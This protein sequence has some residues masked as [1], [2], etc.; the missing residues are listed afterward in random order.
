[1]TEPDGGHDRHVF[2][3][4]RRNAVEV[5]PEL[6]E[7]AFTRDRTLSQLGCNSIDRAE[8]VTMTMEELGIL[9]PVHEFQQ[10]HDIGTL[11][12]VLRAYS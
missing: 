2:E 3:A 12:R 4:L 7:G 5:V 9:V 1:M 6:D 8:I 11:V 10:G